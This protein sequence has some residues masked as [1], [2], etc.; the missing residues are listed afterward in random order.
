D[1]DLVVLADRGTTPYTV[2]EASWSETP[3]AT[4]ARLR[5]AAAVLVEPFAPA[6]IYEDFDRVVM[7]DDG[8]GLRSGGTPLPFWGYALVAAVALPLALGAGSVAIGGIDVKA[9]TG[10]ARR[11][12]RGDLA[13]IDS[14]FG[15]LLGLLEML[16]GTDRELVDVSA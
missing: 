14:R 2:S 9:A 8:T 7:L 10:R 4:T 15:T 11:T 5:K 16:G 13:R 3:N 1:P 6:A 12:W